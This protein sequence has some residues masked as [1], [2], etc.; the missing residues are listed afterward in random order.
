[1]YWKVADAPVKAVRF[2]QKLLALPQIAQFQS[3]QNFLLFDWQLCDFSF[4][5]HAVQLFPFLESVNH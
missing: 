3:G 4:S 1:V 5:E 2:F